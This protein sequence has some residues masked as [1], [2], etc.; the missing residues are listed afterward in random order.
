LEERERVCAV[1]QEYFG[2][3]NFLIPWK[4]HRKSTFVA[5]SLKTVT[6]GFLAPHYP[7]DDS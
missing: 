7:Q 6:A 5:D 3:A 4:V 1:R 2:T